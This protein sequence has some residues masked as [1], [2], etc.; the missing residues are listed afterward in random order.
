MPYVYHI[1]SYRRHRATGQAVA[2]INGRDFYLGPYGTTASRR[3]YDRLIAEWQLGGRTLPALGVSVAE[4]M[5]AYCE[6]LKQS[7]RDNHGQVNKS[8]LSAWVC[9]VKPLKHLYASL[10]A[11]EFGPLKLQA[12][13]EEYVKAD[14]ARVT[15]NSQT[16]RIVRMFKWA[17][18]RE[19]IPVAVYQSLKAVEG[20]RRGRSAARETEAVKPV[21]WGTVEATL[22]FVNRHVAAMIRL[23]WLTGMRSGEVCRMRMADL[24][25]TGELWIYRPQLHKTANLGH[26]RTVPLGPQAQA[27]LRPFLKAVPGAYL[28]SPADA[29]TERRAALHASRETPLSCGNR[30]G[31]NVRRHPKKKAGECYAPD[32]YKG[33]IDYALKRA[34]AARA[35]AIG[36][37]V[38]DLAE[39]DR[40]QHWHPHQLR[41]AAATRIRKQYGLEA[42]RAMLGHKSL[43][44]TEIYA[45]QDKGKVEEIARLVG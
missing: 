23:Q 26:A 3:E 18:S 1:P 15:C 32:S 6:H 43:A 16:R 9:A 44:I 41:H 37:A 34:N 40:L 45:E 33:A 20:L 7:A 13:R 27:V 17:V 35:A 5:L 22:P 38:A 8:E 19:L 4:L 39:S 12:V 2:T 36:V 21:A 31:S 14:L 28:F 42:A 29:E 24:D 11:A 10:P 30:P 25:M